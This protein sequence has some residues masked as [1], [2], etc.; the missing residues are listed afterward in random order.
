MLNNKL[1]RQCV[2]EIVLHEN[3]YPL[4]KEWTCCK[5]YWYWIFQ[6]LKNW[7]TKTDR[8]QNLAKPFLANDQEKIWCA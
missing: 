2:S 3:E 7:L 8:G 6:G 5:A 1:G 4:T